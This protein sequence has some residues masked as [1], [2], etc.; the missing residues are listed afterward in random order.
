MNTHAITMTESKN[1]KNEED[2]PILSFVIQQYHI[3]KSE[4]SV[5]CEQ[6][7]ILSKC[8]IVVSVTGNIKNIMFIE[9]DNI[10]V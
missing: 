10:F 6:Q 1:N 9:R 8:N 5:Y 4:L 3:Y 7:F 2:P